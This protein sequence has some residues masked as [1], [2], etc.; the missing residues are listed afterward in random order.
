LLRS[1]WIDPRKYP[2]FAW[3]WITR[4]LV[5]M[6][7]W[8]V[9]PFIQYYLRDVNHVKNPELMTGLLMAVVLVGATFTGFLGGKVADRIGPK[10]VVYAANIMI[11]ITSV[12][13]IFS[14][15]LAFTFTVA[16][17]YGLGYGAYYSVDW[18]LGCAVLPSKSDA[19]KDMGVWHTSMVLPQSIAPFIAGQMLE[20]IGGVL[21]GHYSLT[22]YSAVFVLAAV[23]LL[24]G[25][26]GLRNVRGVR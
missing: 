11:A 9:Q 13:F 14:Q 8:C 15:S 4:A 21:P 17:I 22:G 19:A 20:R 10:R 16:A 26:L 1:L 3:V 2:D 6:G 5:T 18:A 24:F 12:A 25:A 7:M 23:F